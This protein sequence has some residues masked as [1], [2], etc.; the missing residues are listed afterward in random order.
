MAAASSYVGCKRTLSRSKNG[1]IA[2]DRVWDLT[3]S[4]SGELKL[5]GT[6]ERKEEE[7]LEQV[8]S[9]K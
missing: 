2:R 7:V 6:R 9:E 4:I 8:R 3:G 5:R 1:C